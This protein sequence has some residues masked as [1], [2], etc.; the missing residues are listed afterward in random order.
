M[1]LSVLQQHCVSIF[2]TSCGLYDTALISDTQNPEISGLVGLATSV[3][4]HLKS[5]VECTNH[6]RV[7]KIET[8]HCSVAQTRH[9]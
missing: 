1:H 2:L 7:K 8:Q 6:K 9:T 5:I 3:P 4:L